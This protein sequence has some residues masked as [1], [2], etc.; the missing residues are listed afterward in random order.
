MGN[1]LKES[2]TKWSR[3]IGGQDGLIEVAELAAKARFVLLGEASHG[4]SEFYSVRAELSKKL[5]SEHGYKFIAVE[6]DWPACQAINSYIKDDEDNRSPEEVLKVFHRW[7]TWMWANQEIAEFVGWLKEY[8]KTLPND[9]KVGFYGLDVYSL[10]ES[11]DEIVNY[12]KKINSPDLQAAIDAFSCFEPFNR[13]NETYVMS[14]GYLSDGC[15]NEVAE[16]LASIRKSVRQDKLEPE[17]ALSL[18]INALVAR[19][20][21]QYYRLMVLSDAGSWNTRDAH[22]VETLNSIMNFHGKDAKAI[23]WEH[24]THVGD[25][26]ATDMQRVGMVNVGQIVREQNGTKDV[27]ICGFGTHRGTVIAADQWGAPLKVMEVPPAQAFSWEDELFQSGDEDKLLIFTDE[28]KKEFRKE[29]GHRAIGVVYDPR[30]EKF[31]NY[32]PSSISMRY[33]AFIFISQSNALRPIL[34]EG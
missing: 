27:F 22:M 29:I 25:A 28:N 23:V 4:T 21:E 34:M 19:N 2:I 5:I 16:L 10:W 12:L 26:R 18:E 20:A 32:V 30:F 33:D 9:K 1:E 8:N 11:M 24:N 15:R 31:G 17:K 7:P 3:P 14:A 13:S 6:G